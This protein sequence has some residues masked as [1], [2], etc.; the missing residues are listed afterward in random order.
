MSRDLR[1]SLRLKFAFSFALAGVVLVLV[2]ALAIHFLNRQQ[3]SQLIDQIVSDEMQ[4]LLEQFERQG[5]CT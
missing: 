5:R 1:H 2:H 3:E 4:G